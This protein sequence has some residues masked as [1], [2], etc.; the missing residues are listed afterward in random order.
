MKR[1]NRLYEGKSKILYSGPTPNTNILFFKDDVST[2]SAANR[3]IL[4]GKGVLNNR[5]S[6]YIFTK[7]QLLGIPTHFI[8]RI[9]MREQ[10]I[11]TAEIIPLQLV[12]RNAATG[13]LAKRFRLEEGSALPQTIIEFYYKEPSLGCP[14]VAEEHIAAF[15]WA[16]SQEIE[17]IIQYCIRINDF[18]LGLFTAIDIN[19]LDF[20]LEFGRVY[21]DNL[22]QLIVADEISPDTAKLYDTRTGT[23]LG[24]EQADVNYKELINGYKETASRLGLFKKTHIGN[25]VIPYL[26]Q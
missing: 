10:L 5:I 16:T 21:N 11:R 3:E 15:G 22:M 23:I 4:D 20:K 12:I 6:E 17:D 1:R 26:V 9:N 19:L 7:L 18:L 8:Q 24:R 13:S 14:L 25:N 2:I